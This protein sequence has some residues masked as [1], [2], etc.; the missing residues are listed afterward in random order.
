[1]AT[2]ILMSALAA[3]SCTAQTEV[4]VAPVDIEVEKAEV[5]DVLGQF[6]ESWETEDL[7]LFSRVMAHDPDMVDFGTDAAERWVGWDALR[8]SMQQQMDAY[9]SFEPSVKEQVVKVHETGTVAWFSS[10]LNLRIVPADGDPIELEG[11]RATGVLEKRAGNWLIV[12]FH[13]SLPVAGQAVE[14]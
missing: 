1:M 6:W 8:E 14:Y 11:V 12:Q 9:E 3:W 13:G 7:E 2:A 5:T 10:V 4:A